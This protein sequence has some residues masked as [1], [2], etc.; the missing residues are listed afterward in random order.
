ML[1]AY[2]PYQ[3]A[4]DRHSDAASVTSSA[5]HDPSRSHSGR[6]ASSHQNGSKRRFSLRPVTRNRVLL[7]LNQLS[8]M[9]QN[10]IE[11][12][13]ALESVG[14]HCTDE[15]LA[16]SLKEIHESVRSGQSFSAAVG[17]HGTYFPTTLAPIL[18]AAEASGEVPEALK[19]V[20]ARMRGELKMYGTIIGALI[21]PVILIGASTVVMSALI[22]GV[23]PQ[24]SKV[25]A[26]MGKPVPI[27]TQVL[28]SFG[29]FC[30]TYWSGILPLLVATVIALVMLRRHA[31][32][33]KPLA[34][35]LMYGPLIRDAYRPLQAGRNMR[36]IASM[37]QGGVPL[38]QAI[39][40]TQKTTHD[41]YWQGLLRKIEDRLIDGAPASSAMVG[42]DFVPAEAAQLMATAERT[43]RVAE[44]LEDIGEFYEEEAERRIKRLVVTLEPA[45]IVIM[46]VLVAA[47]VMSVMLPLLDVST[48]G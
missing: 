24:F 25:F 6:P 19:R 3:P 35:F 44:V 23:L 43:G 33:K 26:S 10:G 32:I 20:V 18:A 22:L 48:V 41:I 8:V 39:R 47:I 4:E 28:L 31:V 9:S 34:K 42:I 12:A 13:D 37:V 21:Y 14:R 7:T 45:I 36:T 46:G 29:D 2:A 11:I 5:D 40:L 27:Y 1:P 30:R 38:M 16:Q 17:I 15:R